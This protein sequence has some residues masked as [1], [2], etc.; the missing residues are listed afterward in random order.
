VRIELDALC[1]A[2]QRRPQFLI[3]FG[4]VADVLARFDAH[5]VEAAQAVKTPVVLIAAIPENHDSCAP[6]WCY[7]MDG[8][9]KGHVE[10]PDFDIRRI[11]LASVALF[12][13][14]LVRGQARSCS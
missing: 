6:C 12:N 5:L 13:H 1:R 8:L 10:L 3:E 14:P 7:Y 2:A 11:G 9:I 4:Q